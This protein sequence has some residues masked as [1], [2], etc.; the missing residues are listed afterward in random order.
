M[1]E[2]TITLELT[3]GDNVLYSL[4]R[5]RDYPILFIYA[6]PKFVGRAQS[7]SQVRHIRPDFGLDC[8]VPTLRDTSHFV[9]S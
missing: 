3:F 2:T 8:P 6:K 9:Q 1:S 7:T 4:F 5:M